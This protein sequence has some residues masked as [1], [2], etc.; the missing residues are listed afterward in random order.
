MGTLAR[1]WGRRGCLPDEGKLSKS[2]HP[3]P[4]EMQGPGQEEGV[5]S[6]Q[7]KAWL[8]VTGHTVT[9]VHSGTALRTG[10]C[11]PI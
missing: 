11:F 9:P 2:T 5:D 4:T 3:Q 6:D 10:C 8:W 7:E 1:G